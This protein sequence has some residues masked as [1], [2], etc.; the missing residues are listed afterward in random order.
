M[1]YPVRGGGTARQKGTGSSVDGNTGRRGRGGVAD[2]GWT[3]QAAAALPSPLRCRSPPCETRPAHANPTPNATSSFVSPPPA[4]LALPPRASNPDPAV[5][6][7][8]GER[9]AHGARRP[10]PTGEAACRPPPEGGQPA[11][12]PRPQPRHTQ[13]AAVRGIQLR[14]GFCVQDSGSRPRWSESSSCNESRRATSTM[15]AVTTP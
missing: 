5:L 13:C 4:P 10:A 1:E 14:C 6:P 2:G 11:H 7:S 3:L 8:G 15:S 12:E 9:R